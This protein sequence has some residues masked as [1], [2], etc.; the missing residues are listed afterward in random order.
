[1]AE[2]LAWKYNL[3]HDLE[4]LDASGMLGLVK[5]AESY[6]PRRGTPERFWAWSQIRLEILRQHRDSR[7]W[8]AL[9]SPLD[10]IPEPAAPAM[11]A[12]E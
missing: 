5:A 8:D 12:P 9:K 4:D 3:L 10:E 11:L 6:D 1:M 7:Q 2:K